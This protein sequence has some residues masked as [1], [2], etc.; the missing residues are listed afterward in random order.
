V[1]EA[2]QGFLVAIVSGIGVGGFW[3][4]QSTLITG[5]TRPDQRPSAFAMQRVVMNLGIGLGALAGGLIA[6]TD[7]PGSF[8]V[9][10]L[11]DA[12]T[13]LVYA[14]VMLVSCLSRPLAGGHARGTG[15]YRDVL[16][17]RAF[18]AVIA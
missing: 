10:F 5:L 15:S 7:S 14:C 8:T 2:W 18:V 6:T 17:H 16:R 9:L 1:H 4:S 13:F 3:P 11:L 12:A